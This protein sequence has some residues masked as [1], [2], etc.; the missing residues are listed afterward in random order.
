MQYEMRGIYADIEGRGVSATPSGDT[1]NQYLPISRVLP[2][3]HH[4]PTPLRSRAGRR[5]QTYLVAGR[6]EFAGVSEIWRQLYATGE[7]VRV[8]R[9]AWFG[10]TK[11][12][13]AVVMN[14]VLAYLCKLAS[15]NAIWFK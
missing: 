12:R 8:R 15:L 1:I 7:G 9:A 5:E 11:V 6:R 2:H 4:S 3:R 13:T 10:R 14:S